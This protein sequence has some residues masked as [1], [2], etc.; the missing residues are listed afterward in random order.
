MHPKSPF[1]VEA[2]EKICRPCVDDILFQ[3][4]ERAIVC[5]KGRGAL[6]KI[7]ETVKRLNEEY[8][9][10]KHASRCSECVKESRRMRQAMARLLELKTRLRKEARNI[11]SR[12]KIS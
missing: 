12:N 9:N 7:K 1:S 8:Y 6:I 3:L 10:L 4:D 5:D 2:K 11:V